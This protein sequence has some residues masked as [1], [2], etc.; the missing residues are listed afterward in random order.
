MDGALQLQDIHLPESASFWPP[1]LGWWILL[2]LIIFLSVWAILAARKKAKQRRYRQG[3]LSQ[4][5][6]LEG[7]LT[8]QPNNQ[9]IAEI[10]TFLRQLAI[11][12]Y[13]REEIA[14]LTGADWLHFLDR[15]GNTEGFS[16]GAGRILV[17]AP[18][19]AD[20][21]HNLNLAEFTPLVRS[22][23]RKNVRN[24]GGVL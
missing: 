4:L 16:K 12:N 10:N 6:Y 19:Q 15:S 5:E 23:V 21:I 24:R 7:K 2:T 3:I 9:N 1:A 14:R 17:D 22:W 8:K 13:P 20:D 18:Y 11:T